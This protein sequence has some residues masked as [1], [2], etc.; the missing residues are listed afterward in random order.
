MASWH[1]REAQPVSR[2]KVIGTL[3]RWSPIISR[4]ERTLSQFAGQE[5]E[6]ATLEEL[7][8]QVEAGRGQIVGIV[9][10][11][12]EGN[13]GCCTNFDSILHEVVTAAQEQHNTFLLSRMKNHLGW[14]SRE[15]GAVSRAI[16]VD[17]ESIDLGRTHGIANVEIS[18]IINLGLATWRSGSLH[19]P[20]RTLLSR[21]TG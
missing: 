3:P 4:G 12:G 15:L 18:A 1:Y 7:L 16:E 2:Y 10:E 9:A 17:H 11:A 13:L 14:F 8:T 20:G 5:R 6:L 21:S 19:V